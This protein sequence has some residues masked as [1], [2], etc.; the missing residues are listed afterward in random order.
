MILQLGESHVLYKS[1]IVIS[2]KHPANTKKKSLRMNMCLYF[3]KKQVTSTLYGDQSCG[4][5]C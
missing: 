1:I 3:K 4:I 2:T 5:I